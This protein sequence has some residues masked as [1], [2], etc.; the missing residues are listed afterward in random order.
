MT[1]L[2]ITTA[3]QSINNHNQNN[4]NVKSKVLI[5]KSATVIPVQSKKTVEQ[6]PSKLSE[7][8]K[9]TLPS[10]NL[11]PITLLPS[12]DNYDNNIS[13]IY[14]PSTSNVLKVIN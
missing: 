7:R 2:N 3:N 12:I 14:I 1:N 4:E 5:D 6:K 9:V 13:S 10:S 8:L 11:P